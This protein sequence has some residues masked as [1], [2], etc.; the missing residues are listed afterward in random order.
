MSPDRTGWLSPVLPPPDRMEACEAWTEV[1]PTTEAEAGSG[2]EVT[3]E[4][5]DAAESLKE[6]AAMPT[7]DFFVEACALSV[8]YFFYCKKKI[9]K[10][11]SRPTG[12]Q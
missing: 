12:Y 7:S 9:I 8:L 10:N 1:G 6:A 4:A 11:P 2:E 3:A 5:A